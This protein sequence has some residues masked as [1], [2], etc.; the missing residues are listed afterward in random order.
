MSLFTK[1][2]LDITHL[3]RDDNFSTFASSSMVGFITFVAV[4][5]YIVGLL[6]KMFTAVMV[7]AVS[8]F[9]GVFFKD[10]AEKIKNKLY[11][12]R[13]KKLDKG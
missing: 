7:A 6:L 8:G 3:F 13:N 1:F 5:D 11:G 12:R 10:V 2:Y 4:E 9:A